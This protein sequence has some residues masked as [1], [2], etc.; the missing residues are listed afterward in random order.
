VAVVV[1]V[2]VTKPGTAAGRWRRDLGAL[3]EGIALEHMEHLGFRALA[4]NEHMRVGELDLI[5][6]D[7]E[8]M[9]FVEVKA[10]RIAHGRRAS[11]WTQGFGLPSQKQRRRQRG[12]ARRW[13][14]TTGDRPWARDL[15]FDV[16]RLLVGDEGG[17]VQLDH[18][19]GI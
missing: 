19:E 9:V 11:C 3:G 7:G 6:W 18:I 12:A 2:T 14:S 10:R 17:I 1:S 5:V 13:L 8:T 15:R 16:I 4:R